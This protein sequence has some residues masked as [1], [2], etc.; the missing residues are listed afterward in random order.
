MWTEETIFGVRH[1][2]NVHLY[3]TV[4]ELNRFLSSPKSTGTMETHEH[5]LTA[6]R[7]MLDNVTSFTNERQHGEAY[8]YF[9]N[10]MLYGVLTHC[11]FFHP[12]LKSCVEQ[13]KYHLHSLST[14][15]FSKTSAFI[16]SAEQ[17]ISRLN[18]NK[19]TDAVKLAW[20]QGLVNERKRNFETLQKHRND[21]VNELRDIA[22]YISVNLG[23]IA[24]RC[25]KSIAVLRDVQNDGHEERRLL[26]EI[27][28][29]F[30]EDL[31]QSLRQN[32]VTQKDLEAAKKDSAVLSQEISLLL[33][34]DMKA[35]T[36]LYGSIQQHTRKAAGDIDTLLRWAENSNDF[37]FEELV[38]LFRKIEKVLVTLT[39]NHDF[40]IKA[41]ATLSATA[42]RDILVETRATMH[43]SLFKHLRTERRV[44]VERRS[45]R[46]RRSSRY[47]RVGVPERRQTTDRRSGKERRG[48]E[49]NV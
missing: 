32:L 2:S 47:E 39:S 44:H 17:E 31:R 1:G 5:D 36:A 24:Q 49:I 21:L 46:D 3:P 14:L 38:N 43:H 48:A 40:R 9:R 26:E 42:R 7:E 18:P 15:Q 23:R 20:L 27:K 11:S 28:T 29:R 22:L 41:P 8:D 34:E 4:E 33:R 25:R 16:A 13:F 37:V 10:R 45:G 35:L 19:K 12:S 6:Y 30:K